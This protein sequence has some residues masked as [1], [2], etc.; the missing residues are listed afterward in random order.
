MFPFKNSSDYLS[1]AKSY[2]SLVSFALDQAEEML[3][4][5]DLEWLIS[6]MPGIISM[7]NSVGYLRGQDGFFLDNRPQP[8]SEIQKE[9]YGMEDEVE[10]RLQKLTDAMSDSEVSDAYLERLT[11]YFIR[12][13]SKK[14]A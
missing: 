6:R 5:K 8:L 7:V 12:A 4:K 1:F 11:Q 3:D 13:R 14:T 10:S 9:L 2:Y